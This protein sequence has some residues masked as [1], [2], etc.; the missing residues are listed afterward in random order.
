MLQDLIL[1][2]SSIAYLQGPVMSFLLI[3]VGEL[4]LLQEKRDLS[5]ITGNRAKILDLINM[6]NLQILDSM[7]M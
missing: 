2:Q 6:K 4:D 7:E 1:T 3:K 5:M